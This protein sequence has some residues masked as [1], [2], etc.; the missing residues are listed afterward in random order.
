MRTAFRHLLGALAFLA[1]VAP[2]C[3]PSMPEVRRVDP[4]AQTDI[5][6]RW[7]DT[8]SRLVSEAMIDDMLE[9]AW[10]DAFHRK[11]GD[12]KPR[13]IVGTVR[14]RSHEHINV[15]TFVADLERAITNSGQA[16]FVAS[17][18]EREEVRDERVDQAQHASE[19]TRKEPG[20]EHAADYMLQGEINST[21]DKAGGVAAV[22][23]QVN[24]TL[25]DLETNEKVWIG[26]KKIKKV[27]ERGAWSP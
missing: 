26:E 13:I 20:R 4:T 7:N 15:R 5:S 25:I 12:K 23:Y 3:G 27:V 21:I 8:D 24:M 16:V 19:E 14:N 9:G 2:G 22:Y 17:R 18:W 10:L 6:G 11:H 1:F